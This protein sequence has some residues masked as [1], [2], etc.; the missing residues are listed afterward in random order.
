MSS[1]SHRA[2]FEDLRSLGFGSIS[3]SYTAI[4]SAFKNPPRIVYIY[5]GTDADM[6]I[7]TNGTSDKFPLPSQSGIVWDV[8]A[9][10]TENGNELNFAQG[11]RW[12]GKQ[13]SGAPTTG[14][15]YLALMYAGE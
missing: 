13:L 2:Q 7:S 11:E 9:N 15:I 5:N 4:G 12:F 3:G 8:T 1:L 6:L 10:R 14:A